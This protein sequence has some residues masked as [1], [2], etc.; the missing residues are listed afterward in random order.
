MTM[1]RFAEHIISLSN[2][3][4]GISNLKL[5]KILY[6]TLGEYIK[7]HGI[8][9]LVNDIYTEPFEAWSYGPVVRSEYFRNQ[10]FGRYNIRRETTTNSNYNEL[11]SY[12][13]NNV[14]R[15]ISSLIEDS[16]NRPTWYNNRE[17]IL[18]NQKIIYSLE[19]LQN[20]FR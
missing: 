15:S 14:N 19:D 20:D 12:F 16:H 5:Q 6:F 13:N 9:D 3:H 1:Q 18:R 4:G 11:N 17:A 7:D 8:N 2:N 10:R